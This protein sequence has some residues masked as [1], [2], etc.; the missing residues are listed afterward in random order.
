MPAKFAKVA[1]TR[2]LDQQI[3]NEIGCTSTSIV[4]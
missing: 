3:C 4:L 1:G 2:L